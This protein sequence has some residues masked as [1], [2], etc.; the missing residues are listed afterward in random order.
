MFIFRRPTEINVVSPISAMTTIVSER[1]DVSITLHWFSSN[2]KI[3]MKSFWNAF[4]LNQ[5]VLLNVIPC[6]S[7]VYIYYRACR[8]KFKLCESH[9]VSSSQKCSSK[10][11]VNWFHSRVNVKSTCIVMEV[12]YSASIYN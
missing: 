7:M 5:T 11:D 3:M 9:Q 8:D 1:Y 4:N 10:S 2:Y 6:F 12:D